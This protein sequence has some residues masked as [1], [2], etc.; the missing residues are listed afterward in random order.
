[1]M[2]KMLSAI[3]AAIVTIKITTAIVTT[4]AIIVVMAIAVAMVVAAGNF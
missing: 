4:M 1:M 3:E 2:T